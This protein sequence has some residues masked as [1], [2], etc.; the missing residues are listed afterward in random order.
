MAPLQVAFPCAASRLASP[1]TVLLV[2]AL[3]SSTSQVRGRC[4]S[5]ESFQRHDVQRNGSATL[6]YE[7]FLEI[8]LSAP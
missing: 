4:V 6:R 2:P 7:D 8:V 5:T 1:S 3:W